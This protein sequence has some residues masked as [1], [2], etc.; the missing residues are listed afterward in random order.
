MKNKHLIGFIMRIISTMA[1]G[2]V[3]G[4]TIRD[5]GH[6]ILWYVIGLV[7]LTAAILVG[8]YLEK[9]R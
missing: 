7:T 3:A 6:E 8:A 5:F 4:C 9:K 2:I 1:L